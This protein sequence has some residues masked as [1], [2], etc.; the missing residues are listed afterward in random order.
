MTE[1][2]NV[3]SVAVPVWPTLVGVVADL[4]G[5]VIARSAGPAHAAQSRP[6]PSWLE[7]CSLR[8]WLYPNGKMS[9]HLS[10]NRCPAPVEEHG[11]V[12]DE[13]RARL[14]GWDAYVRAMRVGD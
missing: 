5:V 12:C 3:P 10:E 14:A 13:C 7:P 4:E 6:Y 2:R 9:V 11:L 1:N 8:V